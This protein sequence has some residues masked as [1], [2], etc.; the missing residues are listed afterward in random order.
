MRGAAPA[1]LASLNR[2][3]AADSG[4]RE[5]PAD[6]PAP[7]GDLQGELDAFTTIDACVEARARL[8]PLVGEAIEAIGY[9]TFL[10]DACRLLDAAKA[11]DPRRCDTV[12]ATSLRERCEATVAEVTGDAD[13]CP[14][15]TPARPRL[16]RDPGCVAIA[17]RDTRLC[18]GAARSSTQVTC[19]AVV[20]HD[21]ARCGALSTP[22]EMERCARA[23]DR[24]RAVLPAASQDRAAAFQTSGTVRVDAFDA[25]APE[26]DVALG[27]D[28]RHGVVVNEERDGSHVVVG[29]L[30]E[31]GLD[32]VAP[33]PYVRATL[34][35]EMVA[36]AGR[37][38]A[39]NGTEARIERAELVVPGRAAVATPA[40]RSTLRATSARFEAKR[41]ASLEVTIEGTLSSAVGDWRVRGRLVTFVR[42]VVRRESG[43]A[44]GGPSVLFR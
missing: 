26:L 3:A 4:A 14:W 17:L 40:A 19:E 33:S 27:L 38:S 34:A 21:R 22:S 43:Q 36:T 24:W 15:T 2:V 13:A 7:A 23:A 16:G 18:A 12:G 28:V 9:D 11:R 30:S 8:D 42:D 5:W 41:G 35:F 25:G 37:S 39:A 6:P 31:S 29:P 1:P 20:T 10:Q 44:A 32:F